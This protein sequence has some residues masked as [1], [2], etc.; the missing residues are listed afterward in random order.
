MLPA[1]EFAEEML[2]LLPYT[3]N[4]QQRCVAH[5][6]ARFCASPREDVVFVLNGYAG[7]GKTSLTGALVGMLEA[8][9]VKCMLMAPTGR[10]A[11]VFSANS[12]GHPAW[13]IHRKI[14][15]HMPQNPGGGGAPMAQG[16]SGA[17]MTRDNTYRN[18]V[19]IVDEAS[20]IGGEGEGGGGLLE[21][22]ITY[23]YS[24]DNCRMILVGDTAQ[25]PPVGS[26]R[27]PAMNPEVLRGYG[28]RVSSATLTET[29]RQA[30]DSG[31]LFNATRLRR[32]MLA[33]SRALAASGGCAADVALPVPKL[34]A[35]GLDDVRVID[36]AEELPEL[37]DRCYREDGAGE[38]ILI[39]RSNRRAL[40]YNL[41]VRNLVLYR[42]EVLGAGDMLIV[43]KNHYFPG[44]K[45]KGL[46]FI[47]N[48]DMLRVEKVYGTELKYGLRFADV[49]VTIADTITFDIKL[50]IDGLYSEGAALTQEQYSKLYYGILYDPELFAP[51]A[52][53]DVRLR[54]LAT[55]PYWHALQV[56][57]AYAI[58][59]HKAQ[60]GQWQNVFIDLSY[61]PADALGMELYRWLYTAVTRARKRLYLISPPETL[62]EGSR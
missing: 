1:E 52:P 5:A 28:L 29:A 35:E 20:M 32:A 38:T 37:V 57:F 17:A 19:F 24:G 9:G 21:D 58:T 13:T 4:E 16:G 33:C 2:A 42:E 47:A 48:G 34:C 50:L 15:R 11:K 25:L 51:E 60:G 61:I 55:N 56:K 27:S 46:D 54:A 14:Y 18:T 44:A 39:T 40:E 31:I 22:L 12:G 7:T 59:C 10:A 26:G 30:A 8:S 62:I 41:G 45:P 43:A 3:P 53:A 36:D 49:S 6:L 23:V